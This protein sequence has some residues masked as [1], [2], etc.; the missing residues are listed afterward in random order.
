MMSWSL[1][2]RT[3]IQAQKGGNFLYGGLLDR[4]QMESKYMEV[5]TIPYKIF[6]S[7]AEFDTIIPAITSQPYQLCFCNDDIFT[8]SGMESVEVH[9][10]Q[11]FSISLLAMDQMRNQTS[12]HIFAKT[13]ETARLKLNQSNQILLVLFSASC[14]RYLNFLSVL[15]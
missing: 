3:M 9:R 13:S 2:T 5:S 4:C 12:T 7:S 10:G 14:I 15:A 1:L 11:K 6:T 8:C